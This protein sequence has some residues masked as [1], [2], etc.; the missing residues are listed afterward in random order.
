V[1]EGQGF[2]GPF[3][4]RLIRLSP[5]E[6]N[7]IR[8]LLLDTF[9]EDSTLAKIL[10]PHLNI[11]TQKKLISKYMHKVRNKLLTFGLEVFRIR[12]YGYT[13]RPIPRNLNDQ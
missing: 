10:S 9:V 1:P 4:N 2:Y 3:D 12:L 6:Y 13:L 8:P 7:L 5:T 11:D